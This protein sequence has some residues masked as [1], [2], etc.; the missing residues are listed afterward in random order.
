M[1]NDYVKRHKDFVMWRHYVEEHDGQ[2]QACSM[3]VLDTH[4]DDATIVQI[5][6]VLR[7]REIDDKLRMNMRMD[8]TS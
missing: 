3:K 7:I 2:E 6:E 5:K 1:I 8:G 4:K